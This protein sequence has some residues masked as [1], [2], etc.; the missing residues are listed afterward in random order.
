MPITYLAEIE[1]VSE[2]KARVDLIR[3]VIHQEVLKERAGIGVQHSD[4]LA[5]EV[6]Q[7][8][9]ERVPREAKTYYLLIITLYCATL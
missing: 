3:Q 5:K 4:P 6:F 9:V 2:V 7:E 8:R 1:S